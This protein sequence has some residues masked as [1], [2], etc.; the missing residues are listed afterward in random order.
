MG[1]LRAGE[2]TDSVCPR[3]TV[4]Q[5]AARLRSCLGHGGPEGTWQLCSLHSSARPAQSGDP[6]GDN[7]AFSW[8]QGDL[9]ARL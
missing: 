6:I 9:S 3:S 1:G 5:S 4:S 8:W 7:L 2:G